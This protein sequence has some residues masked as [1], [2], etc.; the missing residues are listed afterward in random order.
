[1]IDLQPIINANAPLIHEA[2]S[3]LLYGLIALVLAKVA[4]L[5]NVSARKE[6]LITS[7]EK[8]K[9]I[10]AAVQQ[11]PT[12]VSPSHKKAAALEALEPHLPANLKPLANE[13]IEAS[14]KDLKGT[15]EKGR[16]ESDPPKVE[17][18]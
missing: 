5:L 3:D 17:G 11:D 18:G 15:P 13:L 2:L 14:V 8:A 12:L 9:L 10:V 1:M 7:R 4:K 6:Q 16:R